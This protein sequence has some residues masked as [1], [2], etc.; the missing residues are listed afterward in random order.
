MQDGG[1]TI[2]VKHL[3]KYL[4]ISR[5]LIFTAFKLYHIL[6]KSQ[7]LNSLDKNSPERR[8]AEPFA[9]KTAAKTMRR[10]LKREGKYEKPYFFLTNNFNIVYLL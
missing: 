6:T 4:R 5:P 8:E 1:P 10:N 3:Q 2:R 7:E 9:F